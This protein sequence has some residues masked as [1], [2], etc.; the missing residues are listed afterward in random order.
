MIEF[1]PWYQSGSA[2]VRCQECGAVV[3][4]G[5]TELHTKWHEGITPT[6]PDPECFC[7]HLKSEHTYRTYSLTDACH[8]P[9]RCSC[10]TFQGLED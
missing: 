4:E 7:G 6:P 3:V 10:W 2:L 5:D 1:V 8:P 9:E